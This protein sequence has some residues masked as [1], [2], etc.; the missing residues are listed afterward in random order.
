MATLNQT[1]K[2]EDNVLNYIL[3]VLAGMNF[4]ENGSLIMLFFVIITIL[5]A[6]LNKFNLDGISFA[7]LGFV[8]FGFISNVSFKGISASLTDNIKLINYFG[9]YMC[10]VTGYSSSTDKEK[11]VKRTV[12]S[13]F[14][15]FTLQILLFLIPND[16]LI[17]VEG[18]MIISAWTGEPIAVTLVGLLSCL[19]VGWSFYAIFLSKKPLVIITAILSLI[20]IFYVNF[21]TATRTPIIM[22]LIVYLVM[23]LITSKNVERK[24]RSRLLIGLLVGLLVILLVYS[25]NLFGI[26]DFIL[27]SQLAERFEQVE[28]E[29]SRNEIFVKFLKLM[30]EHILG[31]G[32]ISKIVG[33]NPHNLWQDVYDKMGLFATICFTIVT[34]HVLVNFFRCLS[35]KSC[36]SVDFL[37]MSVT[38]AIFIQCCLEPVINGYP[39]IC[40]CLFFLDGMITQ[41]NNGEKKSL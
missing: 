17:D 34:V 15:G 33:R 24:Q 11:Y 7:L 9:A 40:W 25:F 26:K 41:R 36:T 14:L 16:G 30:P 32:R 13:M 8:F 19:G 21:T 5:R 2:Y 4:F 1:K 31:G 6:D 10:G 27:N 28:F 35:K 39:M 29:T 20:L 12:F 23:L 38:L 37:Y 22:F 3:I 18:R